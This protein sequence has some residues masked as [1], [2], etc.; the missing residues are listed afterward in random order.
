MKNRSLGTKDLSPTAV[1]SLKGQTGATGAQGPAGA[2]GTKGDKGDDG[3]DGENA[4]VDAAVA[5]TTDA[6][7]TTSATFADV[8]GATTFISV[9]FGRTATVIATFSAESTCSG[10]SAGDWCSVQIVLGSSPMDPDDG[11]VD[12]AFDS[13]DDGNGTNAYEHHAIVR[14]KASVFAGGYSVRAQAAVNSD[15]APPT[16]RLDEPS[17]AVQV[18]VD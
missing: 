4:V 2:Q 16:F 5:N 7:T 1:G 9:P 14:T 13:V 8:T 6:F 10:G 11:G 12:S 3:A 17:L 18:I 15:T